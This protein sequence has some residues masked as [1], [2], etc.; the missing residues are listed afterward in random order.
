M[1][2]VGLF[3]G[4][5][6]L[7]LGLQRAGHEVNLFCEIDDAARIVLE[8][9]FPDVP[10]SSDIRKLRRLPSDTGIVVAGFPC[11]DLSQ[12]G[13]TAGIRGSSSGLVDHVFELLGRHEVPWLLLE[14]VAFMLRLHQGAAMEHLVR[15][16]ER[17]GYSWAYRVIDSRA[18]GLP[19]RRRRVY[20]L[21]SKDADPAS[22]IFASNEEP[23]TQSVGLGHAVGFYWTEGNTG[24]GWAVDALPTLKGGSA[25]GIPSPPA[26]WMPTDEIV[27]PT[28]EAAERI[29]GFP[30]GWTSP[31]NE[32]VQ[33][34]E[35]WRLV[36]NAV[37]VP[38]A[39]WFGRRVLAQPSRHPRKSF[40]LPRNAPWPAAAFGYPTGNRY[41]V[42]VSEWPVALKCKSLA[43][44]LG[45]DIEYLS[46]R[47]TKGFLDRLKRSSLRRPAAFDRA[48]EAHVRR[49]S[50]FSNQLNTASA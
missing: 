19:Q 31:A 47:A 45:S 8:T 25:L 30:R 9:R 33:P 13:R 17:L 3:A 43:V 7:E 29:Q 41:G 18:F 42:E 39:E 10:I 4:I 23:V 38:V 27:V 22:L 20:L 44:C 5:G 46:E 16:L 40:D 12:A 11:Q 2:S 34:R 15:R 49:M 28:I 24:L 1:R 26:A 14:N 48:L 32:V 21:A 36:G 50:K 37:S 6:G 35:R